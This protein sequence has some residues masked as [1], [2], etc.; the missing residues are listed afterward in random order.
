MVSE[1]AAQPETKITN[2]ETVADRRRNVIHSLQE[3]I[4][5]IRRTDS[6]WMNSSTNAEKRPRV[7]NESRV[8]L[9]ASA[10][11]ALLEKEP[12]A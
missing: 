5:K 4:G 3:V 7:R 6:W 10:L 12:G 11:L 1:P 8:V 2:L 9:D